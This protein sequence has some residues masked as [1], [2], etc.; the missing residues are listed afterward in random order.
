VAK[1]FTADA[2]SEAKQEGSNMNLNN[3]KCLHNYSVASMVIYFIQLHST[4]IHPSHPLTY[5]CERNGPAKSS[6][7]HNHLHLTVD[8]LMAHQVG[9]KRQRKHVE[10]TRNEAEKHAHEEEK[11]VPPPVTAS[12][13]AHADVQENEELGEHCEGLEDVMRRHL[14]CRRQIVAGEN[15]LQKSTK[16]VIMMDKTYECRRTY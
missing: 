12:E 15:L 1:K 8:N 2:E 11:E 4:C 5:Q 3:E 6:E 10:K 16:K 7:P 14:R 9:D 13:D